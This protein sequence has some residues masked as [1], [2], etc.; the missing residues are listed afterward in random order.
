MLIAC[1]YPCG[2][3]GA[4]GSFGGATY[5]AL[6]SF[7]KTH[8]LDA[9]GIYGAKSKAALTAAYKATTQ[10]SEKKGEEK[11]SSK[12]KTTKKK[13]IIDGVDYSPVFDPKFYLNNYPDLKRAFGDDEEAALNHFRV[14]GRREARQA[15]PNFNPHNY[16]ERY[17]D[18]RLAFGYNWPSY[19]THFI[20]YGQKENRNGK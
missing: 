16:R 18:L 4:D 15:S 1:G 14:Y 7:Q 19:Y 20:S 13:Y 11:K 6:K 8:D 10:E 17:E 9:D 12:K 3:A 2:S 5:A